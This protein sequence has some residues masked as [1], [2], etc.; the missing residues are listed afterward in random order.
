MQY[1]ASSMSLS[2]FKH[3]SK[4]GNGGEKCLHLDEFMING[5]FLVEEYSLLGVDDG[6]F[7]IL[8]VC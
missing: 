5:V 1:V 2:S 7:K 8:I 6:P 3:I 4:L